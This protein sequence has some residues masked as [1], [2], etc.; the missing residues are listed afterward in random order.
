MIAN[1]PMALP[2]QCL[3]SL[4]ATAWKDNGSSLSPYASITN[5]L[6]R[7]FNTALAGGVHRAFEALCGAGYG[8]SREL[9]VAHTYLPLFRPFASPQA[10][11]FA[12]DRAVAGTPSSIARIL[13]AFDTARI[14]QAR[15]YCPACA[16][17]DFARHGFGYARRVHQV[18]GVDFCPIHEDPLFRLR[19]TSRAALPNCGLLLSPDDF[20]E[21]VEW[22][23]DDHVSNSQDAV[24]LRFGRF[25]AETLNGTL[26]SL[27]PKQRRAL[28]TERINSTR[29]YPADPKSLPHRFEKIVDSAAPRTWLERIVFDPKSGTS[30]QW[31]ATFIT[32]IAL[33]EDPSVGLLCAAV[34]FEGPD[35]YNSHAA[36]FADTDPGY[37]KVGAKGFPWRSRSPVAPT[38][39]LMR[40]LLCRPTF[41][42]ARDF[43]LLPGVVNQLIDT[44]PSLRERRQRVKFRKG[45]LGY[46]RIL[47]Q[48]AKSNPQEASRRGALLADETAYRW[49][50]AYD[51][52][53][54]EALLPRRRPGGTSARKGTASANVPKIPHRRKRGSV[55]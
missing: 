48:Y 16:R 1:I 7:Q 22:T 38:L 25:V 8:N 14:R 27:G 21:P 17:S 15:W 13:T 52:Q 19:A 18:V 29:R 41:E 32:G 31:P 42:V 20:V 50:L 23:A 43:G 6:G 28:L 37:I 35:D 4:L 45:L 34:L 9:A 44:Y 39:R 30:M 36:H 40:A 3:D 53:F 51:S 11:E 49:V 12:L 33:Q 54:I 5:A 47:V 10:Y 55:L 24:R 26:A 46:K 2:D